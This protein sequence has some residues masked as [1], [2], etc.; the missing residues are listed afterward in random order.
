MKK[1]LAVILA[2]F[3]VLAISGC[4]KNVENSTASSS[5]VSGST[6]SSESGDSSKITGG[7][8][9]MWAWDDEGPSEGQIIP[10]FNQEYPDV[11]V[12]Y[13]HV[14]S[15]QYTQKMTVLLASG[16]TFDV[17]LSSN[18]RD[19][20]SIAAKN[21]FLPLD[22]YIA[23]DNY[24]ISS[25]GPLVNGLKVNGQQDALPYR[26]NVWV[27]YYNK[28][29]FD[30]MGVA[31]PSSDMTWDQYKQLCIKMTK[32]AG[33]DK[34][35]GGYYQTWPE[36]W[37]AAALQQG[38]SWM[39]DDLSPFIQ[40]L[41]NKIDLQNA[42]CIM[43][44]AQITATGTLPRTA[45]NTGK[46]ATM[47]MGEWIVQQL[48]QDQ[49][50]GKLNF[51]WDIVPLPHPD[52][53]SA[54]TT[55]GDMAS[56]S[57]NKNSKNVDIAWEFVKFYTS[58]QAAVDYAKTGLVPAFIDDAVKTAYTG[59]GSLPPENLGIIMTAKVMPSSNNNPNF[60]QVYQNI[61]DEASLALAG[62]ITAQQALQAV[63]AQSK[64]LAGN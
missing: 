38:K 3:L 16:D 42:G 40:C 46:V 62:K 49:A 39:D 33:N 34:I 9:T 14:P 22:P 41:Q 36:L 15:A 32:G 12:T 55:M 60:A 30:Q 37:G 63:E 1:F 8:L 43:P 50:A 61:T 47:P 23:R 35:W 51:E 2:V 56:I 27:L 20:G 17:M 19:Y 11:K 7:N 26:K 21:V 52:G 18:M 25:L 4:S 58:E 10:D 31:Y 44:E 57:I 54:N 5:T 6:A 59:D 48:R 45:F 13:N 64:K 28:T 29:I 24:D 53:V